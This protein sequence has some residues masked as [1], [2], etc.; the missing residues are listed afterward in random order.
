M[1]SFAVENEGGELPA[2]TTRKV[3]EVAALVIRFLKCELRQVEELTFSQIRALMYLRETPG[4]SLSEVA[5]F[6]GLQAPTTSKLVDEMVQHGL[7]HRET[8]EDDR[9]RVLLQSTREGVQAL[10]R[11]LMPAHAAL[12]ALLAGLSDADRETVGLAMDRLHP[13]LRPGDRCCRQQAA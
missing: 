2:D 3:M 8:A 5:G 10:E 7:V 13:L 6:L 12:A 11:A 9:R 4:A 1:K